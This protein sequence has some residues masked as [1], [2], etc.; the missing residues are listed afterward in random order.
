MNKEFSDLNRK[1]KGHWKRGLSGKNFST[2]LTT[3]SQNFTAIF[4][5]HALTESMI[6]F[7]LTV[8]RIKC[9]SHYYTPPPCTDILLHYKN[10]Y[11]KSQVTVEFIYQ[12]KYPHKTISRV[13]G[14]HF[15][16]KNKIRQVYLQLVHKIWTCAYVPSTRGCVCG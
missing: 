10:I 7:A 12:G 6:L 15:I 1:Q 8:V 13:C 4:R 3:S 14:Y 5:A 9:W 16:H 11:L 2:S